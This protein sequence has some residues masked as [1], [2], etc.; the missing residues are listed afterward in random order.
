[1]LTWKYVNFLNIKGKHNFK[2]FY[3]TKCRNTNP[4][5]E[6]THENVQSCSSNEKS[7]FLFWLWL[8]LS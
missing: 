4:K 6:I 5:R 8:E 2:Q 3:Y 7:E 1:M